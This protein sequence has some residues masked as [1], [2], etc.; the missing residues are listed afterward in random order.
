M[1]RFCGDDKTAILPA[2]LPLAYVRLVNVD[3]VGAFGAYVLFGR[4]IEA[5]TLR[6]LR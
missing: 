4:A 3:N 6:R 1:I 2:A 5:E